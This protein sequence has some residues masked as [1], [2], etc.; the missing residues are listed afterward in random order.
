MD[1]DELLRELALEASKYPLGT[2]ERRRIVARIL[3]ILS[4]PGKLCRPP[5]PAQ[6]QGRYEEIYAVAKQRLFLYIYEKIELYDPS[7]REFLGWVNWLLKKRFPDFIEE[8]INMGRNWDSERVTRQPPEDCQI[9]DQNSPS[10]NPLPSEEIR[11]C[12]EEDPTG[13]FKATY[14]SGNPQANF[15]YIALKRL[16]GYQWSELSQE[17]GVP[18]PALSNFYRR[19]L[20]RFIPIFRDYLSK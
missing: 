8:S 14:T 16:D 3:I 2:K 19:C 10:D 13:E 7:R 1:E 11:Q 18:I 15:Q 17:L 4:Q 20:Q 12:L 6:Y 9:P 5:C